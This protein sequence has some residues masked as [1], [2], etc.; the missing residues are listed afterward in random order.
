MPHLDLE[1]SHGRDTSMSLPIITLP[2]RAWQPSLNLHG[3]S[4]VT[5][6]IYA[7]AGMQWILPG[8]WSC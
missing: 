3:K 6:T 7:G 8:G 2:G 5:T 4:K 1:K